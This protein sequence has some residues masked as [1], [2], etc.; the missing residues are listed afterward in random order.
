MKEYQKIRSQLLEMLEELN[1][2]LGQITE[3]VKHS[4]EPLSKDFAEQ[5]TEAENNEVLDALGNAARL[6]VAQ[7]QQALARIDGGDYGICTECGEPIRKK[8][9]EALPFTTKCINC[10]AKEE[11]KASKVYR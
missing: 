6:E 3:H 9:L 11:R 7:I 5:A 10:A 1:T 4:D 2:R 8:R